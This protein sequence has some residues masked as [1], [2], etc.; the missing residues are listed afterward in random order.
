MEISKEINGI[1]ARSSQTLKSSQ[2][3]LLREAENKK[4]KNRIL[5]VS[6]EELSFEDTKLALTEQL[7]QANIQ[8]ANLSQ[9]IGH[10]DNIIRLHQEQLQQAN[11]QV[12]AIDHE[13]AQMKRSIVWQ[14]TMKYHNWFVER[15]IPQGSKGRKYYDTGLKCGRILVNDGPKRLLHK[16]KKYRKSDEIIIDEPKTL[17]SVSVPMTGETFCLTGN[18]SLTVGLAKIA[19]V[20]HVY[21]VDLFEEVCLYLKN[22]PVKYTLLISVCRDDDC[23]TITKKVNNLPNVEHVEI[24]I[25]ENRGRDIAPF[26]VDF[27]QLIKNFEYVCK[28]HT[29]KSLF[30]GSERTE[31]RRYLYDMMLGSSERVHAIMSVFKRDP[32]VGVIYPEMWEGISYWAATWLSNKG[33]AAPL[34]KKLRIRFDS[35]EY[36]DFP[37]GS[38][39]WARR[40]ALE[41]LLDLK[42]RREDFPDERGQT[43][44]ELQHVIERCFVLSAKN[45][46]LKYAVIR[47]KEAHIFSYRS[48]R[49]FHQ[50]IST[51]FAGRFRDA[52]PHAD[53]IS[54]DIFD[55]L[56]IRPFASPDM[57]FE[58][59]EEQV[60]KDFG[61]KNF[62]K[63]RK[64]SENVARGRK[65]F[66]GDVNITEIYSA[67]SELA[68]ISTA[69]TKKLCDLEISTEKDLLKPREGII[70][71]AR[72]AKN[73][74]KRIIIISDTY[75]EKKYIRNILLAKGID[76]Y[77]ALY[78]SC[79]IGKRKDRGDLWESVL[80]LEGVDKRKFLHIGDNEQS[81]IQA[82]VD[83]RFMYPLHVMRPS[84]LFRQ[85]ELGE[86]LWNLF[87]PYEGWRANL[88]Y[89]MIANLFCADPCPKE[90]FESKEPLS[91]PYALGYTIFGPMIF[92]FLSW[93][94]KSSNK[95]GIS[96]LKFLSREGFLLS[97][98]FEALVT[99]PRIKNS[100]AILPKGTYFLC[101][102]RAMMIAAM[103]TEKDIPMLIKTYFRGTLRAFF[104]KRFNVPDMETI[105]TILSPSVLDQMVALPNDYD[106]IHAW[107]VKVFDVLS[108]QAECDREAL[109]QYGVEQ[110]VSGSEKIGL[111]DVGYSGSI[112]KTLSILL[113]KPFTGYYF[114]L[115]KSA[116]E[117]SLRGSILRAYF[118]EFDDSD[119]NKSGLL[120]SRYSLLIEA[121]LTAPHGQ[122]ICFRQSSA[123]TVPV[124]KEPGISQKE[125]HT[126]HRIHEGIIKFIVNMLDQFGPCALDIE[127]SN[128]LIQ[129]CYELVATGELNI[130]GLE[131]VLSV[132]DDFCGNGEIPV[133]KFYMGK[134]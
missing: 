13:I 119:P 60:A 50:Y 31:W 105:E 4:P 24:K 106:Q 121:I 53:V 66:Q 86:I 71:L 37:T 73:S 58:F 62:Y 107:I 51:Q 80:V 68:K 129:R 25:V 118:G 46:G 56:L 100:G 33:K 95:D 75:L 122:L 21:Y 18:E 87:K 78:I 81:D 29:K 69:T 64:D 5:K 35:D 93:L 28:I 32:S 23:A 94:I 20:V 114:A 14:V 127:F 52:L 84:T 10:K 79:E 59:L 22:I 17:N 16:S 101:S 19:V 41:P 63:L 123:G 91:D 108:E 98:A 45:K 120:I 8:I 96:Q 15:I 125:F 1:R 109:L 12:A 112:Q 70:E 40:E 113:E 111:V 67:F 11:A 82:L 26:F 85:S 57:V 128:D 103:R 92:N 3:V 76:F 134:K 131:S 83:R 47:D 104:E 9:E 27:A 36:I 72:D 44:G 117:S 97:Q 39:F 124:F 110:G 7:K 48:E 2:D 74:G 42:L 43:D 34:L 49:N 89:G 88:S 126:I 132:E 38:M 30:T 55:T 90:F 133:L 61:I 54:F 102:R 77:D 115:E 65:Q 116:S 130:G 99:H 6:R